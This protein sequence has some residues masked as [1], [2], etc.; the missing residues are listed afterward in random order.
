[1]A[2]LEQK[3]PYNKDYAEALGDDIEMDPRMREVLRT[4]QQT[5]ALNPAEFPH[6]PYNIPATRRNLVASMFPVNSYD[7]T[8]VMTAAVDWTMVGEIDVSQRNR[9]LVTNDSLL[10]L[11]ALASERSGRYT[12]S[13]EPYLYLSEVPF[14]KRKE[15][16]TGRVENTKALLGESILA[17]LLLPPT[18]RI[19]IPAKEAMERY[20]E[21]KR[22]SYAESKEEWIPGLNASFFTDERR[23]KLAGVKLSLLTD[24]A[25]DQRIRGFHAH[26]SQLRAEMHWI[27]KYVANTG[28]FDRAQAQTNGS[29]AQLY[30]PETIL[31]ASQSTLLAESLRNKYEATIAAAEASGIVLSD[32][33]RDPELLKLVDR[34][35]KKR[36]KEGKPI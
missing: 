19:R 21:K 28:I 26:P 12:E 17:Q 31:S 10:V 14:E 9:Y 23:K 2:E 36:T 13:K 1:M 7:F 34:I 35:I 33:D 27:L 30:T 29:E 20:R 25:E 18:R 8:E 32:E 22:T 5:I 11:I 3:P 24:Q 4:S 15:Y 6:F 16:A